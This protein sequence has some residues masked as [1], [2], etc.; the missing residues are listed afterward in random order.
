MKL[1]GLAKEI[2]LFPFRLFYSIF[3]TVPLKIAPWLGL[4]VQLDSGKSTKQLVLDSKSIEQDRYSIKPGLKLTGVV[5]SREFGNADEILGNTIASQLIIDS[6]I[7]LPEVKCLTLESN[8]FALLVPKN[9]KGFESENEFKDMKVLME[10][11][12]KEMISRINCYMSHGVEFRKHVLVKV[13]KLA[14]CH[15]EEFNGLQINK[16]DLGSEIAS[17]ISVMEEVFKGEKIVSADT[18]KQY[19][20]RVWTP[21]CKLW[22]DECAN[23]YSRF[24]ERMRDVMRFYSEKNMSEESKLK[25]DEF[26]IEEARVFTNNKHD[27]RFWSNGKRTRR[28]SRT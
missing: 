28:S 22:T 16:K 7:I 23:F 13:C 26:L 20:E 15:S 1:V 21:L 18:K 17:K 24:N 25:W 11:Y 5:G 10:L 3:I 6:H 4:K 14:K 12:S 9:I 19:R 8:K 27:N 2:L